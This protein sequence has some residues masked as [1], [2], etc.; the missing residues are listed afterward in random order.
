MP[1]LTPGLQPVTKDGPDP[2]T[3]P[4]S[5]IGQFTV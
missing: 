5:Q 1:V 4:T 3:A 2:A